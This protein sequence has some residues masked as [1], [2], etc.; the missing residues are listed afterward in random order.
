MRNQVFT[1]NGHPTRLVRHS[2]VNHQI[3]HENAAAIQT[4][5]ECA[6]ERMITGI[7][8]VL[9]SYDAALTVALV[10]DGQPDNVESAR[11]TITSADRRLA[12]AAVCRIVNRWLHH[13]EF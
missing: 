6:R 8:K 11:T 1:A 7:A 12:Q 2:S 3:R 13:R 5:M 4:K 10:A 9:A